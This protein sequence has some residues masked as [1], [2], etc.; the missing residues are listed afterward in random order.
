MVIPA[1]VLL[2]AAKV[3]LRAPAAEQ[4]SNAVDGLASC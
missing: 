2:R 1:K 4:A 3:L